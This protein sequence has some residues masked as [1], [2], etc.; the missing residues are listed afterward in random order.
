MSAELDQAL[1]IAHAFFLGVSPSA[2]T[3]R[4]ILSTAA[5]IAKSSGLDPEDIRAFLVAERC[6]S[7]PEA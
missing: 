1:S 2:W 3:D 5:S 6:A 7:R 4:D